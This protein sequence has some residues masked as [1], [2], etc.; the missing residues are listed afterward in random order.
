MGPDDVVRATLARAEKLAKRPVTGNALLNLL[1]RADC[2]LEQRLGAIVRRMGGPKATFTVAQMTAARSQ[3]RLVTRYVEHRM[4]GLTV[5]QAELAISAG[6]ADTVRLL[7][8]FERKFTGIA[9]PLRVAQ[10]ASKDFVISRTA[11]S[12]LR[13]HRSSVQRY[14]QW[15]I[16]RMER[17]L[18]SGLL[19]HASQDE[20]VAEV[21][22]QGFVSKRWMAERVVR[23]EIQHAYNGASLESIE[24][25]KRQD[26]PDMGKKILAH[27]DN[28][29]AYDSAVVHGQVRPTSGTF[30]D[31]AGRVYQRPPARPNDREVVIPWRLVWPEEKS[32]RPA[33]WQEIVAAKA[34]EG[35]V[36]KSD[37]A[38]ARV[39]VRAE[40]AAHVRKRISARRVG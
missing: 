37:R 9:Q 11:A 31:G 3:I 15:N 14:G 29:T 28:R 10:A 25:A 21:M 6:H 23:T 4:L 7:T 32:T 17:L 2:D 22:A 35:S 36:T 20:V 30:Q 34:R 13:Q 5:A 1:R 40:A 26:F 18:A 8:V 12:L 24:E 39:A 16:A 38:A 19:R 27:F 33:S